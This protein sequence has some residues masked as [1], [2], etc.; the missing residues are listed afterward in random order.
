MT[1]ILRTYSPLLTGVLCFFVLT[2]ANTK[3]EHSSADA[4]PATSTCEQTSAVVNTT[5]LTTGYGDPD[6]IDCTCDSEGGT[7]CTEVLDLETGKVS[8]EEATGCSSCHITCKEDGEPVE[9]ES[10]N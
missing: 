3:E 7:S 4:F 2:S 8:C 9:C 1:Q 5:R 10:G 6:E